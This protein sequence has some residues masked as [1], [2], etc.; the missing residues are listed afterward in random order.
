MSARSSADVGDC[1]R[2]SSSSSAHC[3]RPTQGPRPPPPSATAA[4]RSHAPARSRPSSVR[5]IHQLVHDL[6]SDRRTCCAYRGLDSSCR[7][8]KRALLI[9][10]NSPP[11]PPVF[12]TSTSMPSGQH[13]DIPAA[14]E[15]LVAR[16]RQQR[17]ADREQ[18]DHHADAQAE[19]AEQERR[20]PRAQRQVARARGCRSC[21]PQQW[22][23]AD[24]TPIE[25]VD[26][27]AR[28][29]GQLLV[30]CHDDDCHA[31]AIEA[32][33]QRDDSRAGRASSSPVGSS[34]RSSVGRFASARAIATRCCSPPDSSA[35][36]CP[37]ALG[38]PD[39]A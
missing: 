28:C 4:R 15:L 23:V 10:K 26:D 33:E 12:I 11:T 1:Q 2:R 22:F 25:H 6:R 18:H 14:N 24:D 34:A 31:V 9:E 8:R 29:T 39:V 13:R 27:A 35:G 38:E 37:L 36:R 20:S 32:I 19:P 16:L 17:L 3:P 21:A 7:S 5:E 30:V